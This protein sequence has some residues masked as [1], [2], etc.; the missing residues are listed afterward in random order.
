M[1]SAPIALRLASGSLTP[2]SFSRNRVP[3]STATRGTLK[4]ARRRLEDGVAMGLPA[5]LLVRQPRQQHARVAN[6]QVRAAE[7]AD[8][9][10]LDPA[11][12]LVHEQLHPVADAH[13]GNAQFEQRRLQ[14]WCAIRVD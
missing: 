10:L 13:H 12:Q 14:R 3:A 6:T 7:L 1:N 8:L 11:A 2:L 4:V 5:G 9:S